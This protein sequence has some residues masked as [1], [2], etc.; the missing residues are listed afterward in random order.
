MDPVP[1]NLE[2]DSSIAQPPL[3]PSSEVGSES[4]WR[5]MFEIQQRNMMQLIEAIRTPVSS[6]KIS[7]PEFNPEQPDADP[8]AWCATIDICVNERPLEGAS[9]IIALSKAL[10]GSAS[11]WLSQISHAADT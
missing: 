6:P 2:E 1:P 8:R 10:K 3:P 11:S 4:H 7:L 9:L 5:T